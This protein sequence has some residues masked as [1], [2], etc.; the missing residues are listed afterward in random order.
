MT[1]EVI[2]NPAYAA[3][4]GFTKNQFRRL[5]E[6]YCRAAAAGALAYRTVECDF[7]EGLASYT[8]YKSE[9]HAPALQFLIRKVGP[10]DMMYE[11]YRQ[12]KGLVARSGVFDRAFEKL[13][14]EVET[15]MAQ[16]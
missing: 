6:L 10:R 13:L 1:F 8:Y 2:S 15:L 3:R 12:G 4:T 16:G 7:D 9:H 5:D 11:I 14:A